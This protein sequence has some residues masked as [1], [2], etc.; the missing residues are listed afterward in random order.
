MKLLLDSHALLWYVLNDSRRGTKRMC[1]STSRWFESEVM[2]DATVV[3]FTGA[4]TLDEQTSRAVAVELSALADKMAGRKLV[5]DFSA[6]EYLSSG[7]LG[8]L[9]TL[10]KKLRDLG[11]NLSLINIEPKLYEILEVTKLNKLLN[12]S[13]H[14]Q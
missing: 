14:P 8:V 9:L 13:D 3:R 11:G 5:L 10:N 7:A 2:G 6:V 4:K 1:I 12:V